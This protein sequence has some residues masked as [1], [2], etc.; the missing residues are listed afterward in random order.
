[1]CDA[2]ADKLGITRGPGMRRIVPCAR[3]GHAE[4][5]RALVRELTVEPNCDS[6]YRM[7][8]PMAVT[9]SPV[10]LTSFLRG[11]AKGTD[12]ADA[13]RPYGILEMYVCL[14]CG[15]TEWYCRNPQAIPIGEEFGTEKITAVAEGPYR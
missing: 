11:E 12:G 9:Y 8:V 4:S 6:N 5:V 13:A 14:G 3:C 7:T 2:C 15:F 1:V 10:M